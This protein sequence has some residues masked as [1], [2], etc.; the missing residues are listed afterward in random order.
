VIRRSG[1]LL[2]GMK[3]SKAGKAGGSGGTERRTEGHQLGWMEF[4]ASLQRMHEA[5]AGWRPVVQVPAAG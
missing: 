5:V 1:C 4:L 2:R 3:G